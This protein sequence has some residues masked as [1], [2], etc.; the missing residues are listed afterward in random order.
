[1]NWPGYHWK[2]PEY[3]VNALDMRPDH[4]E[5]KPKYSS[6]LRRL[7]PRLLVVHRDDDWRV[8]DMDSNP[9]DI[10]SYVFV[11]YTNKHFDTSNSK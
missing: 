8:E 5:Y 9:E 6:Q 4:L 1:M 2:W 10:P 3:A 11:S 7:Y